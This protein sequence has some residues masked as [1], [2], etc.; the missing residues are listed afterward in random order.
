MTEPAEKITRA[1]VETFPLGN[2]LYVQDV[3]ARIRFYTHSRREV[4]GLNFP[5]QLRFFQVDYY[6]I[7]RDNIV[8]RTEHKTFGGVV[9]DDDCVKIILSETRKNGRTIIVQ[10]AISETMV[11][12]LDFYN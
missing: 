8:L 7:K 12:I 1:F 4:T 2:I 11:L 10:I 3:R 6:C 9:K 5:Y